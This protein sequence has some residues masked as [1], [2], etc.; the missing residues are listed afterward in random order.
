MSRAR[1]DRVGRELLHAELAEQRMS[2]NQA[3]HNVEGTLSELDEDGEKYTGNL[4]AEEV[5]ELRRRLNRARRVVENYAA[6]VADDAEPWGK[7][8]PSMPYGAY[9]EAVR[10]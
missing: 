7:P 1:W 2:L 3:F 5:G 9:P 10:E 6:R 4:T 8:K